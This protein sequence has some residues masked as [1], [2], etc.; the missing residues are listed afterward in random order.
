MKNLILA[1]GLSLFAGAAMAGGYVAPVETSA[2][3][4]VE[5]Q[6]SW[7][8]LYAGASLSNNDA[9]V[10]NLLDSDAVSYGAFAGFRHQYENNVVVG[11]EGT[12][13]VSENF[14]GPG[15]DTEMYGVEAQ[16]GF[17]FGR[18]LPYASVGLAKAAGEDAV[19]YGIG[20]DYAVT[21]RI[22]AGVKYTRIDLRDVDAESDTVGVRVGFRF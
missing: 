10:A 8:G 5:P 7:T 16:A 17:A 21:D 12:Y 20:V 15:S 3:V 13:A 9:E 22:F 19:T 2:T 11:V 6:F 14:A 1:V 18:V 4:E